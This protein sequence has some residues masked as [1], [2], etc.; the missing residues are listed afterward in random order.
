MQI[1]FVGCNKM[2]LSIAAVVFRESV[3]C[4]SVS[5]LVVPYI[6]VDQQMGNE[7][8]FFFFCGSAGMQHNSLGHHHAIAYFKTSK[9]WNESTQ[10]KMC[11]DTGE[12]ESHVS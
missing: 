5:C 6:T 7:K 9:M 12:A 3:T 2:S 1:F 10:L 8:D 11:S 4:Q